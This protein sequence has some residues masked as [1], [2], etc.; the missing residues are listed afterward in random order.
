MLALDHFF[1]LNPE[2]DKLVS[3][4]YDYGLVMLSLLIAVGASYLGGLTLAAA[5]RRSNT[6]YMQRLHLFSGSAA[7]GFG[8][9]SMHFI[10]MLA[11]EMPTHVH[12]HPPWITALSAAPSLFASWVALSLLARHDLTGQRL[13]GG[14]V[15]V[16][17]AGI[18]AM[19]YLAWPLW[20]SGRHFA[21]TQRYSH[22]RLWWR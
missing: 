5:A 21:T 19:H 8:I 2:A 11:F 7:L 16:G 15:V 1:V 10:G 4:Q 18:G 3:G 9:W 20:R 13:I 14:G 22:C 6:L 17:G 12:Y